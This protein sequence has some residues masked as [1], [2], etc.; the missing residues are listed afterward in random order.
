M[1]TGGHTHVNGFDHATR[2]AE[3]PCQLLSSPLENGTVLSQ[4][5][6]SSLSSDGLSPSEEVD[7]NG[8]P[9]PVDSKNRRYSNVFSNY[10]L[11]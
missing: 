7:V 8:Q 10:H 6:S 2:A 1:F 5:S 11:Y 3:Q 9:V 4:S